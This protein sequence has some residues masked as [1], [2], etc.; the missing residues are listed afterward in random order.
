M[1]LRFDGKVAIVTVSIV[2]LD[3][4]VRVELVNFFFIM[5]MKISPLSGCEK[6]EK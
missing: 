4:P 5:M 1:S 6:N 2:P 3:Q